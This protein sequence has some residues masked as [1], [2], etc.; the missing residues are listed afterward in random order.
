LAGTPSLVAGSLHT[1]AHTKD[2][3]KEKIYD[4]LPEELLHEVHASFHVDKG[5]IVSH[6]ID[7][8]VNLNCDLIVVGNPKE[9]AVARLFYSPV[10]D[11]LLQ[12]APCD[13][14]AVTSPKELPA[15]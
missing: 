15:D 4:L 5:E 2:D 13:I 12:R 11:K 1:K 10:E 9:S 14:Y 7:M 6:I 3:L 8:S